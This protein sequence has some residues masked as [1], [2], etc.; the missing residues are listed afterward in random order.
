MVEQES[1]PTLHQ[2]MIL[3]QTRNQAEAIMVVSD[4]VLE[5]AIIIQADS[6]REEAADLVAEAAQ[7][8]Q[9]PA[10]AVVSEDKI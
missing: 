3:H 4:Q 8:E 10:V 7:A 6:V 5:V 1:E 9:D 2:D